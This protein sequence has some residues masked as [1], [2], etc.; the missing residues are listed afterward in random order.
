MQWYVDMRFCTKIFRSRTGTLRKKFREGTSG[1]AGRRIFRKSL[2]FW[3]H[4][5]MRLNKIWRNNEQNVMKRLLILAFITLYLEKKEKF[6]YSKK[7]RSKQITNIVNHDNKLIWFSKCGN[8]KPVILW[9]LDYRKHFQMPFRT[10]FAGFSSHHHEDIKFE[11]R[12]LHSACTY[13][14]S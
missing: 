6:S 2:F 8:L 3:R 1:K 14:L 9:N 12:N 4:G 10:Q 7:S 11:T 13:K 5:E